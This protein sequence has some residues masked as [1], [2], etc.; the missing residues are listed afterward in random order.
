MR[1]KATQCIAKNNSASPEIKVAIYSVLNNPLSAKS[2][3]I[4]CGEVF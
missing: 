3:V 4:K 2:E 1:A